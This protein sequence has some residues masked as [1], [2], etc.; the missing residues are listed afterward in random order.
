MNTPGLRD[1]V[2]GLFLREV[3]HVSGHG[4]GD[5]EGPAAA[6]AE[7]FAD[8]LSTVRHTSEIGLD[9]FLPGLEGAVDDAAVCGSSRVGDEDVDLAPVLDDGVDEGLDVFRV[10]DVQ[11]VGFGLDAVFF[12]ESGRVLFTALG[13]RGVGDDDIGTHLG[14]AAGGFDA[15]A[16]RAGGT[17]HHD[18]FAFEAEEVEEVGLFW[19]VDS[20]VGG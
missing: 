6:L 5:D 12:C 20:H 15:H 11:L 2:A 8:H 4:A 9:D 17:G 14:T 18:D 10:A 3:G 19:D 13:A 16:A 1:V 7:V